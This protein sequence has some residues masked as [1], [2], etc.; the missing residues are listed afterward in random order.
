MEQGVSSNAVDGYRHPDYSE[1]S[2]V[3]T[4]NQFEPWWLL[5][6][7]E[8]FYVTSVVITNRRDCC[9]ERL[10]NFEIKVCGDQLAMLLTQ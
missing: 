9:S 4:D 5:D 1:K 2:C 10:H 6:L 3:Q 8:N 7:G